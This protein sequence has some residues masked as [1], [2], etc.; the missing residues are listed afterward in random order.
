MNQSIPAPA[1]SPLRQRLI[2]DMNIDHSLWPAGSFLG[3]FHTPTGV[4]NSSRGRNGRFGLQRL[5]VGD[6]QCRQQ[7]FAANG[8]QASFRCFITP[9]RVCWQLQPDSLP[10][11]K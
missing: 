7:A 4:R 11:Y 8:T 5:I 2:D 10:R 6:R 3:D 9:L 1:I